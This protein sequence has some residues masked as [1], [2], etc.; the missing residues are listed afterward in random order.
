LEL[1][2]LRSLALLRLL[3]LPPGLPLLMGLSA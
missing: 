1:P 3:K 2:L